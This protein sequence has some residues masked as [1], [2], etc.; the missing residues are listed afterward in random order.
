MQQA[1]AV[2]ICRSDARLLLG[3]GAYDRD[4]KY[5]IRDEDALRVTLKTS[6]AASWSKVVAGRNPYL[7]VFPASAKA[8]SNIPHGFS[9]HVSHVSSV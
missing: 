4:M 2:R 5:R 9:R 7:I 1:S 3:I 8:G 6:R